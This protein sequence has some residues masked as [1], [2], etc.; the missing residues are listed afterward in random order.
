MTFLRRLFPLALC[1]AA[2]GIGPP[3]LCAQEPVELQR[4]LERF[5]SPDTTDAATQ[6][7]MRMGA[8][9]PQARDYLA[10]RLPSVI[11]KRLDPNVWLNAVQLAGKLKIVETI[12]AI[13]KW[14]RP[15]AQGTVTLGGVMQLRNDPAAKALIAIGNPSVPTLAAL[16]KRGNRHERET[17]AIALHHIGTLAAHQALRDHARVEADPN[18][19]DFILKT[20]CNS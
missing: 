20:L 9:D 5:Q 7:L 6:E 2:T 16:L 11:E 12:P 19:R 17:A 4:L 14:I 13:A 1:I 10:A 3:S 8:S 15:V 18:L